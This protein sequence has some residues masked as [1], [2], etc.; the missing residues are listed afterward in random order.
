[1]ND[2]FH[3]NIPPTH[4]Y[5]VNYPEVVGWLWVQSW[6][7][8]HWHGGCC[9]VKA[10]LCQ[11]TLRKMALVGWVG[12]GFNNRPIQSAWHL[13]HREGRFMPT[14]PTDYVYGR[15]AL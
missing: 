14:H 5:V 10:V 9:T 3:I 13:L 11:P 8:S 7:Q 6:S 4:Q 12:C 15:R 2:H 1:V